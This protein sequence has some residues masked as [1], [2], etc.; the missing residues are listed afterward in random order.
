MVTGRRAKNRR[1]RS[2]WRKSKGLE[3]W[4]GDEAKEK[5]RKRKKVCS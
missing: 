5:T 3:A 2:R 1:I 4:E